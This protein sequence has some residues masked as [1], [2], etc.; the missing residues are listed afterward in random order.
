MKFEYQPVESMAAKFEVVSARTVHHK[1]GQKKYVAYRILIQK[2]GIR[3]DANPVIIE[4]RYNDFL[5]L[6]KTLRRNYPPLTVGIT[7]PRKVIL[8]MSLFPTL[9]CELNVH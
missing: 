9:K 2:D 4:R 6:Y 3:S 5:E 7:F 8:G 1:D